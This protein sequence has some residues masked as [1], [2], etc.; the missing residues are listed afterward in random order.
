MIRSVIIE[1][2]ASHCYALEHLLARHCRDV[3]VLATAATIADGIAIMFKHQ[4]EL[5][6]LDVELADG[7]CFEILESVTT[8]QYIPVFT[9]AHEHYALKAIR[10]AALDYLLK[11]ITIGNLNTAMAKV[12]KQLA[13]VPTAEARIESISP[14]GVGKL[15]LPSSSG[16]ILVELHDI[17]KMEAQGSYTS[18]CMRD[19]SQILAS[20]ALGEFVRQLGGSFMRIHDKH[21]VNLRHIIEYINGKG[22]YVIMS[23]GSTVTVSARKRETLINWIRNSS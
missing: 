22:G 23:D 19:G 20:K 17:L 9:T 11:P 15:P 2:L 12:R 18:V 7:D 8:L 14:L 16:F 5:V 1:D 13:T 4:P 6:F 10:C 3:V 21:I